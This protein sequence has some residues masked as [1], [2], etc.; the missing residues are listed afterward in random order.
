MYY[1]F[2][3]YIIGS[4]TE[5]CA[6]HLMIANVG[7]QAAA[8]KKALSYKNHL[9]LSV[10]YQ[11]I[12]LLLPNNITTTMKVHKVL[13]GFLFKC[14]KYKNLKFKKILNCHCKVTKDSV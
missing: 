2:Y 12:Q 1:I 3:R 11:F 10:R 5:I 8:E 7:R 6:K 9:Q 14:K 13:F 4:T